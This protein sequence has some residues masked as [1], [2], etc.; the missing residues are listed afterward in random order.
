MQSGRKSYQYM[1]NWE[2]TGYYDG[3]IAKY[4]PDGT[5]D[6]FDS[7]DTE[8]SDSAKALTM[9]ADGS[10]YVAGKTFGD[11]DS[12]TNVV[13]LMLLL[14]NIILMAQKIGLN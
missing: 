10:I 9:G 3:F 4:N 6:W 11:L 13:P 1:P 8:E 2:N 12:Q 7:F 14:V 5:L